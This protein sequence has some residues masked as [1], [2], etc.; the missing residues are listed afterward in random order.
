MTDNLHSRATLLGLGAMGRALA[1]TLIHGGL[2][3]TV[4]NRT[5]GKDGELIAAGAVSADSAEAAVD[6]AD[7][8]IVCLFDYTSVRTTLDPIA[9]RLRGRS[10]LNLTSTTPNEA[11]E[12]AR[13]AAEHGIAYLDG[14]IMA[15]PDMIARTGSVLLYSGSR[16]VYDTERTTLELFGSA[17]YLGTDAG[18]ASLHDFALLAG[19][20]A[21]FAG[22]FHGAAMMRTAGVPATD[23]VASAV[24]WLTAMTQALPR[25][26]QIIDGGDYSQ[27]VQTLEFNKAALHAIERASGDA[28][29]RTDIIATIRAL[30]DRQIAEGHVGEAFQRIIE[31]LV[32]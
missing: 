9:G 26:A 1:R 16:E 14:G 23:F 24:S 11:R 32:A 2:T 15:T 17:E 4:W 21:M 5:P 27:G 13:W 30:V 19:M 29:I 8:T 3:T 25:H 20:Y 18:M 10:V 22:F 12:L 31:G 28:G 6:A 7:L